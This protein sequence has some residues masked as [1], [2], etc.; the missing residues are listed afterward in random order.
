MTCDERDELPRVDEKLLDAAGAEHDA[1]APLE[2]AADRARD[3]VGDA[4]TRDDADA[5]RDVAVCLAPR[6]EN[7]LA[8]AV[9][10]VL[11]E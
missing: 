7:L 3:Q 10:R 11:S 9:A 5:L 8:P 2:A 6:E 4:A 1:P